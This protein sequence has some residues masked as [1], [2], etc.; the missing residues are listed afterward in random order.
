MDMING[1]IADK[2]LYFAVPLAATGIL[3]QLFNAADI[4]VIGQYCGSEAMAAVGSNSPVIGLLVNAFVG[5]SLGA[6]V[7][8]SKFTGQKDLQG[9]EKSVH[10]SVLFALLSGIIL[11]IFGEIIAAPLLNLLS[12]PDNV[13]PMALLYLRVYLLGMP[14]IFLYN[15]ESAIFRSQGN[16]QI[17]LICLTVSG[18]CNV[19]LNLFFVCVL[20]MTVNG[21]AAATVISNLISS[22]LLFVFLVKRKDAIRI[23]IKKIRIH[24]SILKSIVKIGLPAGLQGMVFSIS[25]LCVQS[26]VNSLGSDIMAA[27][28]AAFNIEIFVYYIINSFGQSCTTF[29]GQNYGAGNIERCRKV[30]RIGLL[31]NI[32]AALAASAPILIFG[33]SLLRIFINKDIS[34]NSDIIISMGMIRLFYIVIPEFV[35][36]IME[37]MS[38]SMRGYGYSLMPAVATFMGVCGIRILWVYC[39]FPIWGTYDALMSVYP[40]SWVVTAISLM[41]MYINFMKRFKKVQI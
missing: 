36:S 6:N 23:E 4:A 9:I 26:A 2:M 1:S 24:S 17:P 14:V 3:Q 18:V 15:F 27:S 25:N 20:K 12:V 33:R 11:T 38:G 21:V 35:N 34:A 22:A 40:I 39:V 16:T 32:A 29:I 31:L 19:I 13:Y 7:V 5:I 8:I 10:T 41:V 30:T 37:T 28:S